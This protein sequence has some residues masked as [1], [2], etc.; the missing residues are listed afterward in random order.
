MNKLIKS[1]LVLGLFGA[2]ALFAQDTGTTPPASTKPTVGQVLRKGMPGLGVKVDLSKLPADV[3]TMIQDFNAQRDQLLASRKALLET[4][5]GK[6]PEERKAA[7]EQLLASERTLL[8]EH[9][10]LAKEIRGKVRDLRRERAPK[11][12]P[13]GS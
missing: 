12:A 9:R 5:K 11:P 13:G 7:I 10:E 8:Q 3:Q 6:T 4:L 2:S 1:L